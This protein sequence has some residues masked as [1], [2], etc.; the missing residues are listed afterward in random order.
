[1]MRRAALTVLTIGLALQLLGGCLG[2]GVRADASGRDQVDPVT[3]E[4]IPTTARE[5]AA[6]GAAAGAAI[7]GP[8][9]AA[10]GA[11]LAI[12]A[13][14]AIRRIELRKKLRRAE[15]QVHEETGKH[16][17]LKG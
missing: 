5:D 7:G 12:L 15:K 4:K 10:I 14:M 16:V 9:G 1:M 11:A 6:A 8:Q 2:I 3:G 13:G 17:T